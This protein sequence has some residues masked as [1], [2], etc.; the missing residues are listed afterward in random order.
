MLGQRQLTD[1]DLLSSDGDF[2]MFDSGNLY[3]D[4]LFTDAAVRLMKIPESLQT[5]EAWLGED[6]IAQITNLHKYTCVSP[7]GAGLLTV[8]LLV[9]VPASLLTTC[10]WMSRSPVNI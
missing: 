9:L 1:Y 8:S 4:L 3:S 10:L 5:Y 7:D 2:H 6:F